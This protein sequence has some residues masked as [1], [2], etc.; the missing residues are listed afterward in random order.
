VAGSKGFAPLHREK[1]S[2]GPDMPENN[3]SLS[4]LDAINLH[5]KTRNHRAANPKPAFEKI[6]SS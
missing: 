1:G 4:S 5:T 6:F 3:F 2:Y